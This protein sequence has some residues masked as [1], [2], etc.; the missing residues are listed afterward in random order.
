MCA[1]AF[2]Y[3]PPCMRTRKKG[4]VTYLR[5]RSTAYFPKNDAL[6]I[7]L[8][9]EKRQFRVGEPTLVSLQMEGQIE[10]F[11]VCLYGCWHSIMNDQVF[12]LHKTRLTR[13]TLTEPGGRCVRIYHW[14]KQSSAFKGQIINGQQGGTHHLSH[15]CSSILSRITALHKITPDHKEKAQ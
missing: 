4:N 5:E 1:P 7:C 9:S 3:S 6:P 13:F 8:L 12:T 14:I 2:S 11:S 15:F 10:F